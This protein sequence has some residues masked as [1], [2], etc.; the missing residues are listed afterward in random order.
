MVLGGVGVVLLAVGLIAG[1]GFG[2]FPLL[3]LGGILAF[4]GLVWVLVFAFFRRGAQQRGDLLQELVASGQRATVRVAGVSDTGISI[5]DNPRVTLMLE[6]FPEGGGPSYT[7]QKSVTVPRIAVPRVGE[8]HP[9][10]VDRDD[11][12][13][14]VY[15]PEVPAL[16]A[17]ANFEMP[18]PAPAP[19][20]SAWGEA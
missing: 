17:Q 9:A 4:Q 15:G 18:G 19:P 20:P 2:R 13:K 7:V 5:N 6:V 3:L 16:V 1:D 10:L 8:V 12:A 14:L 11:P